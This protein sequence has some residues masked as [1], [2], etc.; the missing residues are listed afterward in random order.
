MELSQF[1]LAVMLLAGVPAGVVLNL[2]YAL[3]DMRA[4]EDGFVKKLLHN[5][6]DFIFAVLAGLMAV[7]TVYFVNDGEFR[8]LVI[9]G[10]IGGF[11]VSHFTLGR[12]VVRLR[13]ATCRFLTVPL[14]WIWAKTFGKLLIKAR[15]RGQDKQTQIRMEKLL[16]LAANGFE[17]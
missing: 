6:K 12:L 8:Y 2:T 16:L 3:T 7:L 10:M 9:V 4:M 11:A 13:D 1:S 14:T 17:N 15:M 5:V